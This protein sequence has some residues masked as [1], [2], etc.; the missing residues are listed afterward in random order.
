MSNESVNQDVKQESVSD[1]E[2]N[3]TVNQDDKQNMIPQARFSEHVR[4]TNA[5]MEEMS[6][7]INS[8]KA[9]EEKDRQKQLEKEG[10]YNQ[11]LEEKDSLILSQEKE[12]KKLRSFKSETDNQIAKEREE[13]MSQL[14]EDQQAIYGELS[15][16]ALKKHI[17]MLN[18]NV[19]K[20]ATNTQQ[21]K[22]VGNQEFGG[23][24][25]WIEYAQNDPKGAE[26][27]IQQHQMGKR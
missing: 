12:L 6:N 17:S 10:N 5:K 24:S 3:L 9:K 19:N 7:I 18:S 11:I 14:P 4:K 1:N 8:Y 22:R 23:Y 26:K 20:V 2:K 27:A 25:N 15:N 16:P 13:L 21:P